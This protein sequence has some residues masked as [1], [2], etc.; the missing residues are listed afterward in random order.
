MLLDG[1]WWNAE[2]TD[3]FNLTGSNKQTRKLGW[4][5]LPKQSEEKVGEKSTMFDLMYPLCFVKNG[6]DK[7]SWQYKYAIDFIQFANS[8]A[9]LAKF[10]KITGCTKAL[11]YTLTSAQYNE[12]SYY[13]K[14]FYD[15]Y[16]SSD[17]VFPYDN[18]LLFAN[19]QSTFNEITGAE[20]SPFYQSAAALK[21]TFVSALERK[22][23]PVSAEDYFAGMYD[24]FKTLDIWK[25]SK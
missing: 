24:Y 23:S 14:T 25:K 1:S 3:A 6:L 2:A 16:K 8:D 15:A 9:Q 17:I 5:P 21:S 4:M 10:T 12:L 20:G 19:N 11:N 18:N 7:N 22:T 13:G